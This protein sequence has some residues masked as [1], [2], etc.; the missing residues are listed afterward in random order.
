MNMELKKFAKDL[1]KRTRKFAAQIIALTLGTLN[2]RHFYNEKGLTLVEL[3]VSITILGII[4]AAAI[5]LLSTALDAN[6]QGEAR[7]KLY[8]EG[9]MA[10]ERMTSGIRRC[11]F[12]LIPNAHNTTRDILAISGVINDDGDYYFNDPLFPKIDEDMNQD[13][14][15]DGDNGINGIDDDGDGFIDEGFGFEDDDE[16]GVSNEDPLDGIDN[17]GDGNIDEDCGWEADADGA[18]GIAGI[19]DDQDGQV[20]EGSI[21]D[22]DEDGSFDETGN[23]P[24]IY[25]FNSGTSTLTESIPY[26]GETADLST[27]VTQFQVTYEAPDTTHGP[28]VQITLTLTGDDGES[29]QFVEYAYPRNVLQ[30]TGK[31][32]R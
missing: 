32:V 27:L 10:M 18:P 22:D 24:I 1:E 13:M 20:D 2:F 16:D 6:S 5:P 9:L 4:G 29:V 26:T 8:Q 25:S 23:I 14:N 30:R 19:D 3:L 7:S 15:E 31:R 17:D 11:T 28:R 21:S 12:L